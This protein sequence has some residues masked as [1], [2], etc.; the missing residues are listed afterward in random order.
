MQTHSDRAEKGAAEIDATR[1][2]ALAKLGIAAGVAYLAPM[3]VHLDRA[4]AFHTPS[5][6]LAA[7]NHQHCKV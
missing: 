1:R 5:E 6:C 2:K 3:I 4:E 7:P